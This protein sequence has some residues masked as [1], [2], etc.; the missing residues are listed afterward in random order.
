MGRRTEGAGSQGPE[1]S[2]AVGHLIPR[3][4]TSVSRKELLPAKLVISSRYASFV[5]LPTV[6]SSV[7][8]IAS[9]FP[10]SSGHPSGCCGFAFDSPD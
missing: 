5:A 10:C 7:A 1:H 2:G 8:I 4:C 6:S 3:P 9:H